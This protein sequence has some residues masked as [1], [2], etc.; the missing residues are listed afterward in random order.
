MNA[1]VTSIANDYAGQPCF[2]DGKPAIV[3][4]RQRPFAIIASLKDSARRVEFAWPTVARIM[5]RDGEFRS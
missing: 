2:L 4:G 3:Q 1:L 5:Q